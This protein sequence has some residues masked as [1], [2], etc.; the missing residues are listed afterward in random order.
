MLAQSLSKNQR[1]TAV[2]EFGLI[3]PVFALLMMGALDVAHTLYMNSVLQGA[4]QKAARDSTLETGTSGA[5]QTTIDNA[6][7]D[8]VLDLHKDATVAFSRRNYKSFSNAASAQA[9]SFTDTNANGVCDAGEPYQDA[10]NNSTWDA[11]GANAGQGGAKDVTIYKVTVTYPHMFPLYKFLG[12]SDMETVVAQTVLANQ[13]YGPQSQY[14]A[15]TV[16]NCP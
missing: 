16:R 2:T 3:F 4:I 9:E 7:K 14:G 15:A 11:D 5:T 13:P 6:V 10:N 12:G 8:Q 1:G